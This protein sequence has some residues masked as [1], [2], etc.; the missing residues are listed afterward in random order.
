MEE[1]ESWVYLINGSVFRP[2]SDI[3]S[4][5]QLITDSILIAC[6]LMGELLSMKN[7]IMIE[8]GCR[9]IPFTHNFNV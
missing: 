6:W 1:A 4:D 2:R 5:F 9:Y 3:Y 8:K 7:N